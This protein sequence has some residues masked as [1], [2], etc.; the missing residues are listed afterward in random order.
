[1]L[2]KSGISHE[3]TRPKIKEIR[4]EIEKREMKEGKNKMKS[5]GNVE[6]VSRQKTRVTYIVSLFGGRSQKLFKY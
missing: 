1:M 4:M 3:T 2:V 5:K 6:R